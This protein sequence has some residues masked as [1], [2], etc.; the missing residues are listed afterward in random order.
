MKFGSL[1]NAI[2]KID[3][4]HKLN[5]IHSNRCDPPE[6]LSYLATQ[7]AFDGERMKER[8]PVSQHQIPTTANYSN[9]CRFYCKMPLIAILVRINPDLCQ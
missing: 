6:T 5:G 8:S 3:V 9:T 2:H 1:E 4:F 7:F